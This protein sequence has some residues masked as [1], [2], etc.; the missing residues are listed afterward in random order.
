MAQFTEKMVKALESIGA[1]KWEKY[2]KSRLY[3]NSGVFTKLCKKVAAYYEEEEIPN[4]MLT[5]WNAAEGYLDL[6]E[7]KHCFGA[8]TSKGSLSRITSEAYNAL[9]SEE[10]LLKY[11]GEQE[12]N[13]EEEEVVEEKKPD[14]TAYYKNINTCKNSYVGICEEIEECDAAAVREELRVNLMY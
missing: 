12:E 10:E 13:V 11:L 4:S 7:G 14:F 8:N 6:A 2:G 3:M 5:L 1:T 9:F